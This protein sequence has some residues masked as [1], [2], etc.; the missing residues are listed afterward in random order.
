MIE[1]VRTSKERVERLEAVIE[2]FVP[3][4]RSRLLYR[5]SKRCVV[6]T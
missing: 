6:S 1:A 4:G 2:E 3:N 5:R